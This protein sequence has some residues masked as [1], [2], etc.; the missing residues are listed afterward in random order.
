MLRVL[1]V[2]HIVIALG[3]IPV[4]AITLVA[5]PLFLIGPIWALLLARRMWRRDPTVLRALRRTHAVF[6]LIDALMIAYGVWMLRAAAE[7]AARGG[8]LLG[9]TGIIPIALGVVLA[10]FSAIT[11]TCTIVLKPAPAQ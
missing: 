1:A 5:A 4:A 2:A 10:M 9:G 3:L 11:L 6:L 8:G 7:S